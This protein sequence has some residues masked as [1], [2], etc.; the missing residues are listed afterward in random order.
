[1]GVVLEIFKKH[2]PDVYMSA[3]PSQRSLRIQGCELNLWKI[4]QR[5]WRAWLQNSEDGSQDDPDLFKS[6]LDFAYSCCA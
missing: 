6:S 4:P 3:C 2:D 5:A 1:M